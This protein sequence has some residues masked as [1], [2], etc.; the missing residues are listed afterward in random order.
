VKTGQALFVKKNLMRDPTASELQEATTWNDKTLTISNRQLRDVLPQL[1]RWYGL[2]I[3][4]VDLPLLDRPVSM[5]ASLDSQMEAIK[6]IEKSA[7]VK[8]GY[9]GK[10][11]VFRDAAPA[12]K[13]K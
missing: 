2:D 7:N 10:T 8:F 11:M 13:K 1:K 6:A 9:E 12:P 4:V 5:Q 3:K